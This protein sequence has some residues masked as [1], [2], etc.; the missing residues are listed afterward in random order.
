MT[1]E[2][3]QTA[4]YAALALLEAQ[5]NGTRNETAEALL[6]D[7]DH[8]ATVRMLASAIRMCAMV[9]GQL[10]E[11]LGHPPETVLQLLRES[12]EDSYNDQESTDE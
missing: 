5:F 10:A 7:D 12:I 8:L 11:I 3:Q 9:T 6:E 4:E 2:N 1:F